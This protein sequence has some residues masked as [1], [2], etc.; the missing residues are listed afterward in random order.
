MRPARTRP[1]ETY[2][3]G[4]L[5][6][7]MS[8]DYIELLRVTGGASDHIAFLGAPLSL[9]ATGELGLVKLRER[10]GSSIS[11]CISHTPQSWAS[12]QGSFASS[13]LSRLA[14]RCRLRIRSSAKGKAL[15]ESS[16]SSVMTRVCSWRASQVW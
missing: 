11:F 7:Y 13:I 1:V 12:R 5:M 10:T 16:T 15:V 2:G 9:T 4:R 6:W 14:M 3:W 8:G